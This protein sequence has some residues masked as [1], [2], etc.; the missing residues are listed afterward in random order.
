[1]WVLKE[2]SNFINQTEGGMLMILSEKERD[3]IVRE[4]MRIYSEGFAENEINF[5]IDFNLSIVIALP[6]ILEIWDIWN[7]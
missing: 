5:N 2:G 1:V 4:W 6:Y 7:K 3:I